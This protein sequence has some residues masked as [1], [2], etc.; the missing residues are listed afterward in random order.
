MNRN[1][2]S[3]KLFQFALWSTKSGFLLMS[4]YLSLLDESYEVEVSLKSW[5]IEQKSYHSEVLI[6]YDS[7]CFKHEILCLK[8]W[9]SALVVLRIGPPTALLKPHSIFNYLRAASRFTTNLFESHSQH[10]RISIWEKP[11]ITLHYSFSRTIPTYPKT[12]KGP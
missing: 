10:S 6:F 5:N 2:K 12:L 9:S 7:A 8:C 3:C 4:G 1:Y 11:W